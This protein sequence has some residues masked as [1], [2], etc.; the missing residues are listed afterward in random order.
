MFRSRHKKLDRL[1]VQFFREEAQNITPPSSEKLWMELTQRAEF[2]GIREIET[3]ISRLQE[4]GSL[5]TGFFAFWKKHRYLTGLAAAC[6]ALIIAFTQIPPVAS[7]I[8]GLVSELL[9]AA[10]GRKGSM[11]LTMLSE[12]ESPALTS[13][14]KGEEL[15][16]KSFALNTD[17]EALPPGELDGAGKDLKV[18]SQPSSGMAAQEEAATSEKIHDVQNQALEEELPRKQIFEEKD[19]FNRSLA[20]AA[21]LAPEGIWQLTYVPDGYDF[22]K[23]FITTTEDLLLSVSQ[24]YENKEGQSFSLAQNFFHDK[25]GWGAGITTA[26]NLARPIQVGPYSGFLLR[27]GSG[28]QTITWVQKN[29]I[30]TLSGQLEEEELY[31]ILA[32][33]KSAGDE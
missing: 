26:D 22:H 25:A 8:K 14:E 24:E 6:F 13:P 30:V 23:G 28:L 9:A 12:E 21:E 10:Q 20:A 19:L 32:S 29:S 31:K 17:K 5:G 4:Q 27:E 7:G 18:E 2:A 1:L 33:L 16:L 11:E 3:K 15:R